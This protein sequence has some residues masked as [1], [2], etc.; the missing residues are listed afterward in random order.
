M[1]RA[2]FLDRDGTINEDVG[3]FC[4]IKEFKLIPKAVEA[5]RLLQERY[6]LF[7]VTNQ[8][9]VARNIFS[10]KDLIAFNAQIERF[11]KK[12]DIVINKTY[13]CPHLKKDGCSCH[14]PRPFFLYEAARDFDVDLKRSVVIGDHPHDIEMGQGVGAFSIYVL[15]GHGEKHR[16]EL[17]ASPDLIADNI[18]D[19]AVWINERKF[20]LCQ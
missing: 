3:Y 15:T 19:A 7:I 2:V 5:L 12:E 11:L 6:A 16:S 20:W 10:E 13:Y 14:K 17:T 9:G 18:Y 4:S 8:S 1:K